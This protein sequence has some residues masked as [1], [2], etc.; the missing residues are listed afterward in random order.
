MM[1]HFNGLDDFKR[2]LYRDKEGTLIDLM[3]WSDLISDDQYKIVK[4]EYVGELFI[5]TVWLGL[6]HFNNSFFE[7]M[8]FS[9]NGTEAMC[10]YQT[11]KEAEFGHE[12]IM[13][14]ARKAY[15]E[16]DGD[17]SKVIEAINEWDN[18]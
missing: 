16:F 8:I 2:G 4:Q 1:N 6:R 13:E 15:E 14:I 3:K 7:T 17:E 9:K 10:R 18:R 11:Q 12:I 5:S